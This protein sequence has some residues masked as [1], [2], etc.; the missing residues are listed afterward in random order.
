MRSGCHEEMDHSKETVLFREQVR[1]RHDKH[2]SEHPRG[3][4][5]NCVSCHGQTVEGE[6]ISVGETT[7]LTCHFYG[8]KQESVA[9]GECLT[10]H[11]QP[12]KTVSFMGQPFNHREFLAG[13]DKVHCSYCH[14]Q[15]TQGDG[16]ISPTRC[17]S[18]HRDSLKEVEDQAK[19]HLVHVSEGHFDC[20]QCHDEI[21][22]GI[23]PMEQQLLAS[24]NCHT[25][26]EGER[27]SLQE[28]IYSG[29]ALAELEVEPDAMYK[30]GVACDGC[31]THVQSGG[32]EGMAFT[33][34]L[35][36]PKQCEDCHGNEMYGQMLTSW[37]EDTKERLGELEP[38]LKQLDETCGTAQVPAKE[39]AKAK[40]LLASANTKLSYVV[41]DGS[42]GAHN[43]AYVSTILD[44]VEEEI[45]K[46]RTLVAKW[47]RAEVGL[48]ETRP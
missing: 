25:C 46:C 22:H 5:L 9:A 41:Q 29:T 19:F 43:I 12:E 30:A 26:H 44:S 33:K 36:G 6:H 48:L 23:H 4:E 13:K 39:L 14:S 15:V 47:K 38:I 45:G 7:C 31:H 16:A 34:K 3:K 2:L 37:Q 8:R 1:F 10:C 20:L 24:G 17:Q 18:C 21:K 42:Y 11:V 27:H 40:K 35:S 28:Q 32:A